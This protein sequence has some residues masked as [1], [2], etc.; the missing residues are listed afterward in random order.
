[1]A[2]LARIHRVREVQARLA[3]AEEAR[4]ADKATA[5]AALHDRIAGLVDA[6]A[7]RPAA[8]GATSLAAAAHYRERLHASAASADAR[9]QTA[10]GQ[11][12]RSRLATRDALRDRTATG[13]LLDRARAD[14]TQAE[15]RREAEAAGASHRPRRNRHDPC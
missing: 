12:D 3:Q 5:E 8:T 2:K 1:M 11:L 14:E 15:A 10:L 6:V 9:L 7:P 4:A 13:K